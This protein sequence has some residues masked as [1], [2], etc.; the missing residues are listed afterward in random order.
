MQMEQGTDDVADNQKHMQTISAQNKHLSQESQRGVCVEL[1]T[2]PAGAHLDAAALA[3][4][5]GRCKKSI[6]RAARRGE[7]PPPI[8]FL[9]RDIWLAGTIQEHLAARQ[10]RALQKAIRRDREIRQHMP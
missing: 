8:K 6:Q 3:R 4:I 1:A 2:L 7:L 5:L 9:G 10:N